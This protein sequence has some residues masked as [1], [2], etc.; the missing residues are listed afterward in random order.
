LAKAGFKNVIKQ[1]Y[2]RYTAPVGCALVYSGGNGHNYGHIEI[3]T[4]PDRYC[5]DYCTNHPIGPATHKLEAVYCL[6]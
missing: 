3:K 2:N 6:P 4:R 1:G 5:S